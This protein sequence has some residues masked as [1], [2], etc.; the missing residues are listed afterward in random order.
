MKYLLLIAIILA[1]LYMRTPANDVILGAVDLQSCIINSATVAIDTIV[2]TL[3]VTMTVD[4]S[5]NLRQAT[6]FWPDL[7]WNRLG[8]RNEV[9]YESA[10]LFHNVTIPNG[11]TVTSAKVS[12][13]NKL[14]GSLTLNI[15]VLVE[16]ADSASIITS[17]SDFSSRVMVEDTVI[18]QITSYS[19][20]TWYDITGL[21]DMMDSMVNRPEW[22]LGNTINVFFK[23]RDADAGNDYLQYETYE[24]GNNHYVTLEAIYEYVE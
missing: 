2:D 20:L 17:Q 18:Y 12:F 3:T 6:G 14:D 5:D 24:V 23:S 22:K 19:A 10:H 15:D 8:S 16:A 21:E 7:S 1:C 9:A 13:Y 4:S 11:A